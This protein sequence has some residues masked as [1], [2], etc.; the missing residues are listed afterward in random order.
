[1]LVKSAMIRPL[2]LAGSPARHHAPR[3]WRSPCGAPWRSST[4]DRVWCP[5]RAPKRGRLHA[6]RCFGFPMPRTTRMRAPFTDHTTRC[7]TVALAPRCRPPRLLAPCR[8]NH[9]ITPA[10][11]EERPG[12]TSGQIGA[13]ALPTR[14][15]P[16]M[17]SGGSETPADRH[18]GS[19][20]AD[21]FRRVTR[22]SKRYSLSGVY[23]TFG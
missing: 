9:L 10:G 7:N 20:A 2:A 21:V 18:A 22:Q 11:G 6:S 8:D 13:P 15:L 14:A 5:R 12:E 16:V 4:R 23:P 1:M 19:R 3:C 17:P